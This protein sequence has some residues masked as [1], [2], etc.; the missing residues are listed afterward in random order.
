MLWGNYLEKGSLVCESS[1]AVY[2]AP[3]GGAGRH[4][5]LPRLRA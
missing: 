3:V 5:E 2:A 1:F 4:R